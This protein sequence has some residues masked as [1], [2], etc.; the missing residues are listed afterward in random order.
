MLRPLLKLGRPSKKREARRTAEAA[1]RPEKPSEERRP[2]LKN[3][4]LEQS[5]KN[6]AKRDAS[7]KARREAI[8]P[9]A[10]QAHK[11]FSI[12]LE[13]KAKEEK[14]KSAAILADIDKKIHQT[15]R[16]IRGIKRSMKKETGCS[17]CS[18][19]S[20]AM[21]QQKLEYLRQLRKKLP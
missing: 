1:E 13:K 3:R 10:R 6:R 2:S 21:T 18:A 12:T 8:R 15:K 17:G 20:L 5:L 11:D 4:I 19:G 9:K 7:L 16:T 14:E